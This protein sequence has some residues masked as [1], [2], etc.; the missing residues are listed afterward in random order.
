M[1]GQETFASHIE[2]GLAELVSPNAA[3]VLEIAQTIHAT[4]TASFKQGTRLA[5]GRIQFKYEEEGS[6]SAGR[7]GLLSIPE[8]LELA[9]APFLGSPALKVNA[10][11]RYRTGPK[12]LLLGYKLERPHVTERAAFLA[13]RDQIT[14]TFEGLETKIVML[15]AEAPAVTTKKEPA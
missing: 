9:V 4:T 3:E 7:D 6:A 12:G 14:G 15:A 2:D 13:V 11:F 5:S 10:R 8:T 1:V